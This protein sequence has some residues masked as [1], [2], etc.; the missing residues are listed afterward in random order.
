MT[1]GES[2]D[3]SLRGGDRP[4]L[5]SLALCD[6]MKLLCSESAEAGSGTAGSIAVALAAGCAAKAAAISAKRSESGQELQ[7]LSETLCVMAEEALA[8]A[9]QESRRFVET[10][11]AKNARSE[12]KLLDTERTLI[13]LAERLMQLLEEVEPRVDHELQGDMLAARALR[14]AG[15]IILASNRNET[16]HR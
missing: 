8:G 7:Q 2:P 4:P 6:L 16:L 13:S 3:S 1:E 11:H 12:R 5:T 15:M 10:L 9:D 14:S